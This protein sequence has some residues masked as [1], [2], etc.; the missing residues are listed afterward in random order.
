MASIIKQPQGR[1]AIQFKSPNGKR[2]TLRMG[3]VPL[4]TAQTIKTHVEALASAAITGQVPPDETARWV[5]RLDE[6]MADKLARVGLIPRRGTVHLGEFLDEYFDKRTDVK[7]PTKR[8][9]R[10]AKRNLLTFFGVDRLITEVTTGDAKDFERFLKT[11]ARESRR[12]DEK[13]GLGSDTVRK[14][15]AHVKQFFQDAVDRELIAKNP[16][17]GLK[18]TMQGNTDRFFFVTHNT[19]VRVLDACPNTNWRL[20]FALCRYG[21]LRCPS[22]V[23]RLRL[24]DVDWE[25][26]RFLVHSP[27]TEHH[28]GKASRW[29]PIFPELRPH[30]EEAWEAAEPGQEH[31]IAQSSSSLSEMMTKIIKRAGLDVW[32]KLFQNLRSTRQTE[33]E[34][35][36]PSHVV[37]AWLGNSVQ[38]ARKH[39]LQ[40]TDDHFAAALQNPVH[41]ALQNAVQQPAAI[42]RNR[43][44]EGDGESESLVSCASTQPIAANCASGDF[45]PGVF[46]GFDAQRVGRLGKHVRFVARRWAFRRVNG[47]NDAVGAH[48]N[49]ANRLARFDC[50]PFA[51]CVVRLV[52]NQHDTAGIHL[53]LGHA[54]AAD[55]RLQPLVF[56]G[57]WQYVLLALWSVQDDHSA[58]RRV[59]PPANNGRDDQW[60]DHRRGGQHGQTDARSSVGMCES[61]DDRRY[62]GKRGQ[63]AEHPA[64]RDED[65]QADEA[66]ACKQQYN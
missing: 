9:W 4:R 43:A 11:K 3:K 20:I 37:C 51:Y 21:G 41:G 18:S 23:L 66:Y 32:P 13:S 26:N 65:L 36:F 39:Y 27:K 50:H 40:V 61:H 44:H 14:R 19:A 17:R 53:G 62:D 6:T 59:G 47:H 42:E 31:F 1:K 2:P 54:A 5:T 16:F 52:V 64:R 25:R 34:E 49:H 30:L 63:N 29:V 55:Q 58:N 10:P 48:G 57:M 45:V 60:N 35:H 8:S 33:L 7:G 56:L 46:Q 24:S 22:E 12:G 28:E 15:I 38:V